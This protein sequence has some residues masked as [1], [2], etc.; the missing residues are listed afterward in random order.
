MSTV[1]I[2]CRDGACNVAG[3]TSSNCYHRYTATRLLTFKLSR[4][5]WEI[6][7]A[8]QVADLPAAAK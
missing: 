4:R 7:K 6:A 1:T 8:S 3:H 5:D 2:F